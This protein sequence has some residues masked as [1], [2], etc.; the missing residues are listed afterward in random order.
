MKILLVAP[1]SDFSTQVERALGQEGHSV[2]RVDERLDRALPGM[3]RQWQILWR[4]GRRIPWWRRRS[5]RVLQEYL[6]RIA[7]TEC[8]DVMLSTKGM[9]IRPA[10]LQALKAMGIR[11][12]CWFPD[13]A[14]NEPY[15]SWVRNVASE[16]DYFFSFDSA[17]YEQTP[18]EMR[19]RV[20]VLPFGVDSHAWDSGPITE[21]D[22]QRYACD[23]CFIGAPYPD[24]VELLSR[25]TDVNLKIF[26]WPGW[27]HT[28][29]ARY[30][31]GLL[32]AR[33]SAKAYRL[34]KICVNTNV[35]PHARGINLKT[36]EIAAAGGFQLTDKLPDLSGSFV[37]G[38]ELDTFVDESDFEKKVRYW[39]EHDEERQRVASAGQERCMRDHTLRA[40]TRMLLETITPSV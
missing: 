23:A 1:G 20:H 15:A 5:N 29:L 16:W 40:R 28:K 10:T 32:N 19:N 31:H 38:S 11:T 2:I 27:K 25:V 4:M 9:N 22:R 37:I 30:Y 26:G 13:N 6:I 39:L 14:A 18:S 24:R 34:A 17:I 7:K 33:E 8:P 36:F 12:A 21:E 3:L 35:Y